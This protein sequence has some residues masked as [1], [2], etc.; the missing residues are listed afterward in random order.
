VIDVDSPPREASPSSNAEAEAEVFVRK[1]FA[2][3]VGPQVRP[4]SPPA[5]VPPP[6][7]EP[8]SSPT[9]PTRA[10]PTPASATPTPAGPSGGVK[11]P[12]LRMKVSSR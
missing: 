3:E 6:R 7:A 12:K 2:E 4:A 11:K 9:V 1:V 8:R 5:G 10:T